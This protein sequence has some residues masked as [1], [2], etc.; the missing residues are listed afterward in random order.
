MT[1]MYG[2]LKCHMYALMFA[3]GGNGNLVHIFNHYQHCR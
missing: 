1:Q 3:L 2:K